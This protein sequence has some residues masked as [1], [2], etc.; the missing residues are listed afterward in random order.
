MMGTPMPPVAMCK[1]VGREREEEKSTPDITLER[2]EEDRKYTD[3]RG[4]AITIPLVE[5]SPRA[6]AQPGRV[7]DMD[8]VDTSTR[9]REETGRGINQPKQ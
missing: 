2:L 9:K 1:Y 3:M 8:P 4:N 7:G 5:D 6:N